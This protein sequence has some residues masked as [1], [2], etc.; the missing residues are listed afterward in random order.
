MEGWDNPSRDYSTLGLRRDAVFREIIVN[1]AET[2]MIALETE[3][4]ASYPQPDWGN[5]KIYQKAGRDP[6]AKEKVRL[7]PY[8]AWDNRGLASMKVWLPLYL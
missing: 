4:G 2:D 8:F 5:G 1:I 3:D 6:A 7:I